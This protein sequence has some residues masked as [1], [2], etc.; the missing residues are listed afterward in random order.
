MRELFTTIT[1]GA[2][3]TMSPMTLGVDYPYL[4]DYLLLPKY[5][6][7]F[8]FQDHNRSCAVCVRFTQGRVTRRALEILQAHLTGQSVD[9]SGDA[10]GVVIQG[11][12]VQDG[13][14][15]KTPC[16]QYMYIY[17]LKSDGMDFSSLAGFVLGEHCE[18]G[19]LGVTRGS[20]SAQNSTK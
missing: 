12:I 4:N 8:T 3:V 17:R 15:F 9:F 20:C 18:G 16:P 10:Q 14:E 7:N 19:Q 11:A 1:L 2:A 5:K 6:T 13:V